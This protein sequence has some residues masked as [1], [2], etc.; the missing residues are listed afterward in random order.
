VY[1]KDPVYNFKTINAGS[2]LKSGIL[3]LLLTET[4]S[5]MDISLTKLKSSQMSI[6]NL[7][8]PISIQIPFSTP[9]G[10]RNTL[11]CAYTT[12]PGDFLS[13]IGLTTSISTNSVTCLTTHLTDF[14]LEEH[15]DTAYVA[16]VEDKSLDPLRVL[17]VHKSFAFWLT[18]LLLIALGPLLMIGIWK[19]RKEIKVYGKRGNQSLRKYA[20]WWVIWMNIRRKGKAVKG[21]K[22]VQLINDSTSNDVTRNSLVF[23][24]TIKSNTAFN[25]ENSPSTEKAEVDN[26]YD[27]TEKRLHSIKPQKANIKKSR[28]FSNAPEFNDSD[29]KDSKPY[30]HEDENSISDDIEEVRSEYSSHIKSKLPP[31]EAEIGLISEEEKARI[32]QNLKQREKKRRNSTKRSTFFDDEKSE[33]RSTATIPINQ[34]TQN[35]SSVHSEGD[36][37]ISVNKKKLKKR[38][39]RRVKKMTEEEKGDV[40]QTE[41]EELE[42]GDEEEKEGNVGTIGQFETGEQPVSLYGPDPNESIRVIKRKKKKILKK[43]KKIR[44]KTHS[45]ADQFENLVK[46]YDMD[47]GKI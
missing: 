15:R 14:M 46:P 41:M 13:S 21:D 17:G 36:D 24:N 34:T 6:T 4:E 5:S 1:T 10:P 27:R 8:T 35:V 9:F 28:F 23:N 26:L 32:E 44:K 11:S 31:P 37:S 19:D 2:S 45:T 3:K 38:K 25:R 30:D 47:E 40:E 43:K 18:L 42:G 29:S 33:G 22:H 20:I 16:Y 39:K 12:S 7:T